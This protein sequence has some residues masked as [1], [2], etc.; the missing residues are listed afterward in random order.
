[1]RITTLASGPAVC[2]VK[3]VVYGRKRRF[4]GLVH[5]LR[6]QVFRVK[7]LG[8]RVSVSFHFLFHYPYIFKGDYRFRFWGS[9]FRV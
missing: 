7:G 8:F 3:L 5:R 6:I 1:M 9:G 2:E 4:R